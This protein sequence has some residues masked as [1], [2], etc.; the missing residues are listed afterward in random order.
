[1]TRRVLVIEDNATIAEGLR[2]NLALEG[3]AVEIALTGERGLTQAR[4]WDPDL[5]ILDL[6]LPGLDGYSVLRTL[7]EEARD[8]PVLILSARGAET[9]RLRG[10]RLG[11]D[12][13]VVK[14]FSLPE[15]L[16]RVAVMLRRHAT[17]E[18]AASPR[19]W[20]FDAVIVDAGAREVMRSGSRVLLR[21]K[22]FDLLLALLRRDGRVATR[23]EL[24]DEVW[25]YEPDVV[26]RTVDVHILELRRKL[27]VEPAEPV[28]ILTVRKTGYRLVREG[29]T[30]PEA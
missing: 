15:L 22:E 10:F 12:D 4:R 3:Y 5:I 28:H 21:P 25:R 6:M 14:P 2:M 13:Y 20:Q 1:M 17:E 9:D 19:S 11:A 30:T 16:A 8:M 26:S 24:L 29:P 7:R 18:R 23:A 27:E